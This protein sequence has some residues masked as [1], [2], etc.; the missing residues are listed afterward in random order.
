MGRG[1]AR[2]EACGEEL[3]RLEKALESCKAQ[4]TRLWS[5]PAA[6]RRF[7]AC[8]V[9]VPGQVGANVEICIGER[10]VARGELVDESGD[11]RLAVRILG[12]AEA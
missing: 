4:L 5:S 8:R 2:A 9:I 3:P 1:D 6:L 10:V 12:A 11:G 7:S